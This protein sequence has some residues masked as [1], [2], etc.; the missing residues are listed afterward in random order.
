MDAIE[1]MLE[2]IE[3]MVDQAEKLSAQVATDFHEEVFSGLPAHTP[4]TLI[5]RLAAVKPIAG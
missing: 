2:G 3:D 4:R 5:R 1:S